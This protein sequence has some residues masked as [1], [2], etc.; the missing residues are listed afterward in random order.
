MA[1]GKVL[2]KLEIAS[3]DAIK[4]DG[5]SIHMALC[6]KPSRWQPPAEALEL[7]SLSKLRNEGNHAAHNAS[8]EDIRD[9]VQTNYTSLRKHLENLFMFV[10]EVDF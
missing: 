9:A 10:F 1:R 6:T 3:W 2:K 5:P 4:E 7:L 8:M